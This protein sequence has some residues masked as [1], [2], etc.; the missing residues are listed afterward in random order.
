MASSGAGSPREEVEQ[1]SRSGINPSGRFALRTFSYRKVGAKKRW[2][3]VKEVLV[4]PK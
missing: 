2:K 3:Q 4:V 1:Q